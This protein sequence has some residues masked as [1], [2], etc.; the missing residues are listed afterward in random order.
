MKLVIDPFIP[1]SWFDLVTLTRTGGHLWS[2]PVEILY[3]F[4]I[5]FICLAFKL[6][7][8]R[9]ATKALFLS[10]LTVICYM[11]CNYNVLKMTSAE[12]GGKYSSILTAFRLSVFVF[13]SGSLIGLLI[14]SVHSSQMLSAVIKRNPV[15]MA[16]SVLSIIQFKR[17]YV[18]SMWPEGEGYMTYIHVPGFQWAI[19][20]LLL[21]L[22]NAAKFNPFIAFL[23]NSVNLQNFGK[24]SFGTY[25]NHFVVINFFKVTDF[26]IFDYKEFPE[27]LVLVV[28][29]VYLVGWAWYVILEKRMIIVANKLCDRLVDKSNKYKA[30]VDTKNKTMI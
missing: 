11:G 1:V 14:H 10:L 21:L 13:L 20:L 2:I 29:L 19:L 3:Y 23:V 27:R 8:Q 5:P 18:I 30:I 24:F 28:F 16:I 9:S 17:A 6:S 4:I 12:S 15:Q 7:S 25:L 22:N 26:K